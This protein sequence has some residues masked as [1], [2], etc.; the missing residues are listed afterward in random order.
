MKHSII[1]TRWNGKD[2]RWIAGIY[3]SEESAKRAL[4]ND[5]PRMV[6]NQMWVDKTLTL[7]DFII[8]PTTYNSIRK[9]TS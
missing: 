5:Y 6:A 7:D 8:E 2:S 4:L 9:Q 3:S 1:G